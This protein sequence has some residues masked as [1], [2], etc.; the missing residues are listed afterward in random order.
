MD[1]ARAQPGFADRSPDSLEVRLLGTV[2]Y[3]AALF[4]Q[5]RLLFELSGREDRTGGLL[6]C[7]HPPMVTIGREGSRAHWNVDEKAFESRLM[8]VRWVNRGG[9]CI[10]HGTGHLAVYPI[11][12]LARLEIG[13][14]GFRRKLEQAVIDA[15][16]DLRIPAWPSE[17][18]HGIS[19]R[20][21]QFATVGAAV[22]SWISYHGV[23]I[24]VAPPMDLVRL[25]NGAPGE[26]RKTCLSALRH[27]PVSMHGVRE[28]LI[29]RIAARFGY[30]HYHVY[31]GHPLL[32]R[33]KKVV[34]VPA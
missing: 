6:M 34:H 8:D 2:D 17:S 26:E 28:A 4:L 21:G 5:E 10:V 30:N 14:D 33:T 7:E 20:L 12:P 9:G 22:K 15:A 25:I 13:I 29:R 19:G 24:D 11:L 1:S 3:D 18:G 31:T 27:R 32:K 16:G 23:F